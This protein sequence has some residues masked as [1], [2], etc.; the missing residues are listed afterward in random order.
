MLTFTIDGVCVE[1]PLARWEGNIGNWWMIGLWQKDHIRPRWCDFQL[2]GIC[3]LERP[4]MWHHEWVPLHKLYGWKCN[5][6]CWWSTQNNNSLI[7]HS[8][9]KFFYVYLEKQALK[10]W[11]SYNNDQGGFFKCITYHK[12]TIY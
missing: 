10:F 11:F 12:S 1:F 7:R 4:Q 5:S 9:I 8:N 3:R 2:I 6:R